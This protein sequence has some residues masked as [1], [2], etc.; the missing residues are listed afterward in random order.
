MDVAKEYLHFVSRR[1]CTVAGCSMPPGG[2]HLRGKYLGGGI[3]L[4]PDDL[5]VIPLCFAHHQELHQNGIL[6][7]ERAHGLDLLRELIQCLQGFAYEL[8]KQINEWIDTQGDT[9]D[10]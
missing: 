8:G 4:R 10:Y 5:T 6:T 1:R 3:S 7:F 9:Y 2:H